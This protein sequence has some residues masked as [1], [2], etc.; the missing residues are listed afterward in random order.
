MEYTFFPN[1][2]FAILNLTGLHIRFLK[3]HM[4]CSKANYTQIVP[5]KYRAY[6]S[7]IL[8]RNLQCEIF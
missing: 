8:L 7:F 1:V 3:M 6:F 5:C 2:F 4:H